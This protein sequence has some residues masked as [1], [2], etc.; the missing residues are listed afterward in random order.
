MKS[1]AVITAVLLLFVAVSVVALIMKQSSNAPESG[2]D[3][4]AVTSEQM[5]ADRLIVY[6]FH[7][8]VRCPTC[9]KLEAYSKEAVETLFADELNSGQVEFQVVNYDE[10]GNE[11]FLTDYDLSF[12][13]LVLVEMKDGKEVRFTNLE[14]IWEL[15]GDKPAYF[16]YVR[17]GLDAYLAVDE[18]TQR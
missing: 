15:V 18:L 7:G 3:G 6:Y 4:D 12:Q 16:E 1:K 10:S 13:S 8:N 5:Q 9:N 14:K 11:H 2:A 17:N